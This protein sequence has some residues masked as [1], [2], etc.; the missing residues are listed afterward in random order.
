[1][2]IEKTIIGVLQHYRQT[3]VCDENGDGYPL[4]DALTLEGHGIDMGI[5]EIENIADAIAAALRRE[6][7]PV[8]H[9]DALA[10]L[11]KE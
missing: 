4:I 1:M 9:P 3:E 2:T 10:L 5:R 6:R 11:T 7:E 8:A